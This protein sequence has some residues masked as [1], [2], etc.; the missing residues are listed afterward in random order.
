MNKKLKKPSTH[1]DGCHVDDRQSSRHDNHKSKKKA[2]V[3][4]EH[5]SCGD[6]DNVGSS[7]IISDDDSVDYQQ[8]SHL[9]TT[10]DYDFGDCDSKDEVEAWSDEDLSSDDQLLSCNCVMGYKGTHERDCPF[11]P[12]K[13]RV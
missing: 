13:K 10:G 1:D 5:D 8:Y 9:F 6:D 12:R 11:D 7:H 2:A 3:S 4:S